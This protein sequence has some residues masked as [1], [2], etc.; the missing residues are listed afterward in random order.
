V[1]IEFYLKITLILSE[2]LFFPTGI[3]YMKLYSTVES[4]WRLESW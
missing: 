4:L 2:K 3:S 1:A